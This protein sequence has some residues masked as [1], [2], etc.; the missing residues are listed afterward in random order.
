MGLEPPRHA[1]AAGGLLTRYIAPTGRAT[2]GTVEGG[3]GPGLA[4]CLAIGVAAAKALAVDL[5]VPLVGVNHLR[6]HAWSPFISLHAET[7]A[8]FDAALAE[9][10]PQ[11]SLGGLAKVSK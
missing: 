5:G 11:P 7:G 8:G 1:P 6:G 4:G 3:L 9:R 2:P 10:L